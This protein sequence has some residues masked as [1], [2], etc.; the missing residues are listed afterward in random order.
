[1]EACL[2]LPEISGPGTHP[3]IAQ[4]LLERQNPDAALMVLRWSG[5]DGGSQLV[6]LGEAVNA[7]RVRVE[8]ALVTEAFMYQR[9]LCTKIKEKQLR[10][11]LASNVPEVS[12]GESRT[13]MDW[14]ETLVTEICCLCIRRGLVDRMIE[15][16]WNFDEEKCLHKCLLEYA[17]DDPSTIV[18][19]LLVVFYLQGIDGQ[20]RLGKG[21]LYNT[22]LCTNAPLLKKIAILQPEGNNFWN[23]HTNHSG[24]FSLSAPGKLKARMKD[25]G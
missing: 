12:K 5:H 17:I 3:K 7:V 23:I 8:C 15:L 18:G 21:L 6:S 1:M 13:W 14:M 4:V 25:R 9:L 2:L 22:A 11:G 10:D 24:A 16:P 19:S 20:F